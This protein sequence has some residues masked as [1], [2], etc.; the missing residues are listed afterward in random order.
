MKRVDRIRD[1]VE[2][3]STPTFVLKGGEIKLFYK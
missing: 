3:C 2:S 1:R